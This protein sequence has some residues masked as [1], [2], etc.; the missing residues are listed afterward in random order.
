MSKSLLIDSSYMIALTFPNDDNHNQA[1]RWAHQIVTRNIKVVVTQ[2]VLLEVGNALSRYLVRDR[3]VT[4]M[5]SLLNDSN[6]EIVPLSPE[7]FE[8]GYSLFRQ[9]MDKD[10]S[11]VDCISFVVMQQRGITQALTADKHFQQMGFHALLLEG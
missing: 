2:A 5:D 7:L 1:V 6:V 8:A 4:I 3:F 11:L 9:R 10:W